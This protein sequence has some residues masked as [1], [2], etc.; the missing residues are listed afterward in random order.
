MPPTSGRVLFGDR[1]ITSPIAE[2]SIVFQD[3]GRS[4][5]PWM[6]AG[7][8]VAF[9]LEG[10]GVPKASRMAAAERYLA[11]VGLPGVA[12]KYPWQMSGGQ[13]Q[14]VAIARALAYESEILLM[15]EPFASVDAQTRFDLEDL[16][17]KLPQRVRR[18]HADRHPRH[19]RGRLS[20]RP[21][22]GDRE[23]PRLGDDD[24]EVA[25]RRGAARHPRADRDSRGAQ[26]DPRSDRH[27]QPGADAT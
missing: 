9:P 2:L 25:V 13:Q 23:E 21:N 24:V 8:N 11:A 26:P 18:E 19:R 4:L 14:R 1:A 6:R 5:M 10:R 20:R 3:Y 16:V 12:G 22:R 27:S 7:Q 15:D 17:L